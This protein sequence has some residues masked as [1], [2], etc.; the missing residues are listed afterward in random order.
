MKAYLAVITVLAL[1]LCGV[2]Y[3][4]QDIIEKMTIAHNDEI[5]N[6]VHYTVKLME[7]NCS[8]QPKGE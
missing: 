4:Q 8:I 7:E 1:F 5:Y 2:I 3:R 6:V